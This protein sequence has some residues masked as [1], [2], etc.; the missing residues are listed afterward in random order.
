MAEPLLDDGVHDVFVVDAT[1]VANED[2]TRGTRLELTLTTGPDKGRVVTVES[3]DHLG[4][5]TDLLGLPATLTVVAG[6]PS[7]QLDR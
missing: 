1:D 3:T 7:V 5:E 4:E 2:G 6:V